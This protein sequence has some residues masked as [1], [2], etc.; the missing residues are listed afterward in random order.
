MRE[1]KI[2]D[3]EDAR[4]DIRNLIRR[5]W[6]DLN[7]HLT[8]ECG[9]PLSIVNASLNLARTSQVVYQT[10]DDHSSVT[11]SVREHTLKLFSDPIPLE[12]TDS[13]EFAVGKT[14]YT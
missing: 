1:K 9:L 10:G 7:S 8:A 3:E 4:K 13:V 5:L 6:V 2:T 14:M 12:F 11:Y